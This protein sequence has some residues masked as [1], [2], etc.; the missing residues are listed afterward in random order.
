MQFDTGKQFIRYDQKVHIYS[1]ALLNNL[2]NLKSLCKGET[3]FCAVIKANGY[4]HG[5]KEIVEILKKGP[6]DFFAVA[7]VYEAAF[8]A[9]IAGQA[10]ILILEPIHTAVGSD[11]VGLCAKKD[12]HCA[13]V[14]MKA[15]WFVQDCLANS[16]DI[17]N[18][19]VK[20]ETGMGR[21]GVDAEKA[22]GLIKKIRS[23]RNVRLAGVYTH[24]STAA[25]KDLSYAQQQ[26]ERFKKF[27]FSQFLLACKDVIIHAANSAAMLNMPESHFD[28]VRCGIAMFGWAEHPGMLNVQLTPAMKFE[29]P[30]VQLNLYKRGQTIGY[31]RTFTAWRDTIGAIVPLGYAD[32]YWRLY[33]NN[34]VMKVGN[35]FARVIGRVSMDKTII[36]VTD[37]QDVKVGQFVTVIDNDP[38][39]QCSVYKLAE[40]ADTICHEVL[41]SLPSRA[42]RII[43]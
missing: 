24:F 22:A 30:I 8:I 34:A 25:E 32:N 28:M 14:D 18:V 43:H 41:T 12:F 6:V 17:L 2:A 27:L 39:S 20:V 40:L 31:G 36:D 10:K 37:I 33:S 29:V 4:G 23:L 7:N 1:K 26:L 9:D 11:A 15:L 3:K 19:H 5:I 42:L 35:N 38:Q 16:S 21:C 13:I